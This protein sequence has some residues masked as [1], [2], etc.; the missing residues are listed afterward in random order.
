MEEE[1]KS[2][3]TTTVN[4][5]PESCLVLPVDIKKSTEEKNEES[6]VQME[7]EMT[8]TV[9][10]TGEDNSES[11][12]KCDIQEMEQGEGECKQSDT[13]M[14]VDVKEE[15]SQK[16]GETTNIDLEAGESSE[17]G[18]GAADG[19]KGES[20]GA[21]PFQYTKR[22]TFTSEIFK[23][24]IFNLPWFGYR[25]RY[26]YIHVF[27]FYENYFVFLCI[28]SFFSHKLCKFWSRQYEQNFYLLL[29]NDMYYMIIFLYC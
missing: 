2:S 24:E 21:D 19:K 15:V 7:K 26:I 10:S 23:I 16:E 22:D 12:T 9:T 5:A 13:A 25:V 17:C 1:I 29:R 28:G 6:Q 14:S 18:V 3:L 11:C 4:P 8:N 20:N 27:Y